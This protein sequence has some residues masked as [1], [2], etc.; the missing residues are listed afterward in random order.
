MTIQTIDYPSKS[1]GRD[2]VSSLHE[3]GFAVLRDH[4]VPRPLLETIYDNW[5]AFFA[6]DEKEQYLFDAISDDG[7][8]AGYFPV[9]ISETAVGHTAKDIK[10]FFHVVPGGPLPPIC[11]DAI[12]QYRELGFALGAQLLSWLQQYTPSG[13]TAD[14]SEPLTGMLCKDASLLR[15]LHYP[16]LKGAE[17]ADALRAAAHE[18]INLI[19]L[20]PVSDQAGLQ[21][22]D[23]NGRWIDVSGNRG[24]LI[25]NSG[26]MLQEAT[27]GYYPST[28]HRVLNPGGSV[29]NVSRISVPF[30]LTPRLEVV[31]SD[32]YT[33]GSYLDE[34]LK[35]ISR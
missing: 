19:T 6:S 26:D 33:S 20:L 10:E 28:S 24:D 25:I 30:F 31:L 29:S 9:Q 11:K 3:T 35:L 4:P 23:N 13:I 22:K 18:D 34:R 15:I 1:A 5:S 12:L 21:V 17:D 32:R 27:G 16:P 14:L 8:R 2:F 7:N